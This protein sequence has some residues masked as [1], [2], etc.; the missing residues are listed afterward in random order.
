MQCR[1]RVTHLCGDGRSYLICLASCAPPTQRSASIRLVTVATGGQHRP[2]L[3]PFSGDGRGPRSF[4]VTHLRGY[5]NVR[6]RDRSV[7]LPAME[8]DC[9]R[10]ERCA[11]MR[12][13][14]VRL[15][16][17]RSGTSR[18]QDKGPR[19]A[20][21]G[22]CCCEIMESTQAIRIMKEFTSKERSAHAK[23]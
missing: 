9:G 16:M 14:N 18:D 13:G 20:R 2:H 15:P 7:F 10:R 4:R 1:H 3:L 5:G 11:K 17:R 21:D 22:T 12:A 6:T 23:R 8:R 19:C